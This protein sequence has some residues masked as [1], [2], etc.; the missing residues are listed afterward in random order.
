MCCLLSIARGM[1]IASR[2]MTVLEQRSVGKLCKLVYEN[3]AKRRAEFLNR[4]YKHVV[5]MQLACA[6]H[7]YLLH[8]VCLD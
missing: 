4:K 3:A 1:N 2:V 5:Y 6:L 7:I 8:S